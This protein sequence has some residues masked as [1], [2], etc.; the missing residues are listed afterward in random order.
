MADSSDTKMDHES[1]L[2]PT[3]SCIQG[4][5]DY[6]TSP[7]RTGPGSSVLSDAD[8]EQSSESNREGAYVPRSNRKRRR[9]EISDNETG[10][11]RST[12]R[13][14]RRDNADDELEEAMVNN[15]LGGL[16]NEAWV[17]ANGTLYE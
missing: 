2:M 15:L 4:L 7:D 5:R 3:Q 16:G 6:L 17:D 10:S 12:V 11:G 8:D 13:R 14:R 9:V 1:Q